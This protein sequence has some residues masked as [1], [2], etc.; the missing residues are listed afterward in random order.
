MVKDD[1][2]LISREHTLYFKPTIDQMD[3]QKA[4]KI[5]RNEWSSHQFNSQFSE[6]NVTSR[7]SVMVQTA[8]ALAFE[9]QGHSGVIK[10]RFS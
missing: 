6:R 5:R 3:Q 9:G 4:R 10:G 1:L 8:K 2:G 7:L